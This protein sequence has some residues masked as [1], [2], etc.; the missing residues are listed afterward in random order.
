MKKDNSPE[1]EEKA[2]VCNLPGRKKDNCRYRYVLDTYAIL[3]VVEGEWGAER[4]VKILTDQHSRLFL[5]VI[6]LGEAYYILLRRKGE[7]IADEV[8]NSI[9]AEEFL[10]LV[11]ASWPKVRNAA[12][13]K[14]RGGLSYADSFVVSLVLEMK[15]PIITGDP[16]IKKVADELNVQL[17]WIGED[18]QA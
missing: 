2:D 11:D 13:V 16:E 5:S 3:A 12:K 9:F 15:A 10:I 1:P 17:I 8:V 4:V 7:E 14:S 6:N 18:E